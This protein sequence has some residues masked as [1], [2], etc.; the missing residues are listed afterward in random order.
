MEACRLLA[1]RGEATRALVRASADPGK[2]AELKRLGA[3]LATGDLRDPAS[4]RAACQGVSAIISSATSVH[5]QDPA[6][7][8]ETVDRQ[9]QLALIDAAEAAGVKH[10]VLVSFPPCS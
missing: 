10:F 9:G 5:S 2:L 6:N 1:K 8:I 7:S 4:L 3:E